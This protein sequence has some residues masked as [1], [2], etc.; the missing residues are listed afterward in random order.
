LTEIGLNQIGFGLSST[1]I[2]Y[3]TADGGASFTEVNPLLTNVNV[4]S[5]V[6]RRGAVFDAGVKAMYTDA[7]ESIVRF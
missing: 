6:E 2:V 4:P 5:D 3:R 7:S 1:G